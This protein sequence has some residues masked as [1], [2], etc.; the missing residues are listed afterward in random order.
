MWNPPPTIEKVN[1]N[2]TLV[3]SGELRDLIPLF[4][5]TRR[6][7]V[8]SLRGALASAN[9]E[10]IRQLAHRMRGVG[11][12]YGFAQ[13]SMLGKY[14]E[15][16]ALTGDRTLLEKLISEYAGYLANVQIAYAE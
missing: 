8:D 14:I 2:D 7:E 11:N 1:N 6:N 15:E 12:S 3:I 13:V 16:C 10:R 9:Y 5:K 4:M